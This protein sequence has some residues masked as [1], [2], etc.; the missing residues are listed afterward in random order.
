MKRNGNIYIAI[1]IS[2]FRQPEINYKSI[3]DDPKC[4]KLI[5]LKLN[6][7]WLINE[8]HD[9]VLLVTQKYNINSFLLLRENLKCLAGSK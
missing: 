3:K 5:M 1:R 2:Y 6:Y 9:N 8:I 7:L 4:T